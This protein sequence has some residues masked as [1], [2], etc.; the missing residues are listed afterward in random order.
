[1]SKVGNG[2]G[3]VPLT[4][5]GGSRNSPPLGGGGSSKPSTARGSKA[6]EITSE[7]KMLKL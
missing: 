4:H 3:D 7:L 6:D 5:G 1:M 2:E